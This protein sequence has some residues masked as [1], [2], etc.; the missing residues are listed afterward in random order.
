MKT[1]SKNPR[2]CIPNVME[3]DINCKLLLLD[4]WNDYGR[5]L[6]FA[7][8]TEQSIE[9]FGCIIHRHDPSDMVRRHSLI[10]LITSPYDDLSEFDIVIYILESKQEVLEQLS[11]YSRIS[12]ELRT[13]IMRQCDAI[14]PKEIDLNETY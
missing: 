6:C 4:M 12:I 9:W 5:W 3:S 14:W 1:I 10:D 8:K 2:E 13:L 11:K 7:R